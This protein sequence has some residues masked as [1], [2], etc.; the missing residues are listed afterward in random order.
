ML[1]VY[2]TVTHNKIQF[3]YYFENNERN[4]Y[5]NECQKRY[6]T[7]HQ[8]ITRKVICNRSF[9]GSFETE[10]ETSMKITV[11]RYVTLLADSFLVR[12]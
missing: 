2:K 8:Y 3:S 4:C 6:N 10:L 1:Q 7:F 12:T 9:H 5:E 11:H